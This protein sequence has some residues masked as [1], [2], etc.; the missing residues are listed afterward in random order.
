MI[1]RRLLIE[2]KIN[3]YQTNQADNASNSKQPPEEQRM[4]C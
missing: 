3:S 2:V 4:Q 1:S